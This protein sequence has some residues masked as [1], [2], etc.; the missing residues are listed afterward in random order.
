[1]NQKKNGLMKIQSIMDNFVFALK[2]IYERGEHVYIWTATTLWQ[3]VKLE[4]SAT[5]VPKAHRQAKKAVKKYQRVH[6]Y[7]NPQI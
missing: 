2:D 6:K 1:M 7:L 5:T 4:G 3:G